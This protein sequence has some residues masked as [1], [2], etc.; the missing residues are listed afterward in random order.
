MYYLAESTRNLIDETAT[1]LV[2]S[3]KDPIFVVESFIINNKNR[4]TEGV[5]SNLWRDVKNWWKGGSGGVAAGRHDI[6]DEYENAKKALLTMVSHIK[7]FAGSDPSTENDILRLLYTTVTNLKTAEPLI[8]T[9]GAK[10]KKR[11]AAARDPRLFGGP[12]EYKTDIDVKD[13]ATLPT[14]NVHFAGGTKPVMEWFLNLKDKKPKLL[15]SIL[16]NARIRKVPTDII[17]LAEKDYEYLKNN[18]DSLITNLGGVGIRNEEMYA[19]VFG[20]LYQK[21]ASGKPTGPAPTDTLVDTFPI[22]KK[23]LKDFKGADITEYINWLS[24]VPA[25][26]LS[27]IKKRTED[28]FGKIELKSIIS[29]SKINVLTLAV[30]NH[31]EGS[32]PAKNALAGMDEIGVL[33]VLAY[34]VAKARE[35]AS[36]P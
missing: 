12:E 5:L 11:A 30:V 18:K 28:E 33:K 1:V 25:V 13:F 10:I 26:D 14:S 2:N 21:L 23:E 3:G 35:K 34:L 17:A 29:P 31:I 16:V 7:K 22:F 32:V 4:F 15:Q 19:R 36:K 8:Q 20:Y 9:L 6:N 24:G 27:E